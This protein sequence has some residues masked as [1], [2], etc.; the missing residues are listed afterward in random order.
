MFR[1][2]P[3]K[4]PC[5]R[6]LFGDSGVVRLTK[7]EVKQHTEEGVYEVER[8]EEGRVIRFKENGIMVAEYIGE[9]TRTD[10]GVE[11]GWIRMS[12]EVFRCEVPR[13]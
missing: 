8:D 7:E 1:P 9:S 5:E 11:K 6:W 2:R 10:A 4:G 13:P 3:N 12:E